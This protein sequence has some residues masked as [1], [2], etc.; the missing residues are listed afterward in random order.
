MN[1]RSFLKP[2]QFQFSGIGA[3]SEKPKNENRVISGKIQ[4][5]AFWGIKKAKI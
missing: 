1:D 2:G 3:I 5:R 4:N